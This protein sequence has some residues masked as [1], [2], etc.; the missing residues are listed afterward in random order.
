MHLCEWR[1]APHAYTVRAITTKSKCGVLQRGGR[2]HRLLHRAGRHV[3]HGRVRGRGGH[4]QLRQDPLLPTH[5]HDPDGGQVTLRPGRGLVPRV[6]A[7]VSPRT[8][9]QEAFKCLFMP[10]VVF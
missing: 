3:G 8:D 2:T 9:K 4:L 6:A 5:Q 1:G 10:P 7:A